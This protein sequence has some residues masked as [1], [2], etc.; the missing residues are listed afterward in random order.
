MFQSP[1]GLLGCPS[2]IPISSPRQFTKLFIREIFVVIYSAS[3]FLILKHFDQ[4]KLR[5]EVILFI[6]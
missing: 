3:T 5:N 6:Q 4:R 1:C 2:L